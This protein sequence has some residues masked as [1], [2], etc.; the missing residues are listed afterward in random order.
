MFLNG[1]FYLYT[2]PSGI[3]YIPQ[4][5]KTEPVFW[6]DHV[7][8]SWYGR[9]IRIGKHQ[10]HLLL[11][12]KHEEIL[13]HKMNNSGES[14]ANL[15]IKEKEGL[16]RDHQDCSTPLETRLA[17]LTQGMQLKVYKY[18]I[19]KKEKL[20]LARARLEINLGRNEQAF[21]LS[22]CDESK[23]FAIHTRRGSSLKASRLIILEL[24]VEKGKFILQDQADF[25]W[26]D[27]RW[28]QGM[29]F[30]G[31]MGHHLTLT[32]ITCDFFKSR[33]LTFD[34]DVE[35]GE[36]NEVRELRK[37]ISVNQPFKLERIGNHFMSSD[38][39]ARM[40]KIGYG[41]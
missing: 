20:I 1:I 37:T 7:G 36:L 5:A 32:A 15:I 19:E 3:Y 24:D 39:D 26:E 11:N 35:L 27:F 12:H 41:Y 10:N 18:D 21:S 33:V 29:S 31:Y 13:I 34:Y 40:I 30:S 2:N 25:G 4:G 6:H 28:F 16:I 9:T 23:I 17:V 14:E 8:N 38:C 22:V